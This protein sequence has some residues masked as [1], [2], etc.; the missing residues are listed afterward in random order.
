MVKLILH[1]HELNW[2]TKLKASSY[3]LLMPKSK[4][5]DFFYR[6]EL[7][8]GLTSFVAAADTAKNTYSFYLTSSVQNKL[9]GKGSCYDDDLVLIPAVRVVENGVAY[10]RQQLWLSSTMF[11]GSS[12]ETDSLKPRL[13]VVYTRR[14]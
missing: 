7:P 6:N 12:C 9:S 2:N 8:D 10:Y 4:V 13:D 3:L 11:Y 14:E 1:R 5:A